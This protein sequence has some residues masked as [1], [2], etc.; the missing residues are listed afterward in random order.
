MLC[1]FMR[2]ITFG[3]GTCDDFPSLF[4]DDDGMLVEFVLLVVPLP[5]PRLS[6]RPLI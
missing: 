2:L 1:Y 6:E 5:P 4:I 3:A